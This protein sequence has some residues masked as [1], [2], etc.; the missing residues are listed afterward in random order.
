MEAADWL[1][2]V[3][4]PGTSYNRWVLDEEIA[5]VVCEQFPDTHRHFIVNC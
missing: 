4:P 2:E 3:R 1:T 5:P